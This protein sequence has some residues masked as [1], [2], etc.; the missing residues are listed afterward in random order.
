[1]ASVADC[2]KAHFIR[3]YDSVM[4]LL[5]QL[6][7][8]A[9][10]DSHKLLWAKSLECISLV[11]MAVGRDRFRTEAHNVMRCM[12]QLQVSR[13]PFCF[14]VARQFALAQRLGS[15]FHVQLLKLS[16][17]QCDANREAHYSGASWHGISWAI[18][19]IQQ[20]P[21]TGHVTMQRGCCIALVCKHHQVA[22]RVR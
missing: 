20:R 21:L 4:P 3:Y 2:A 7:T 19:S 14:H 1:M 11:G 12:Q 22:F 9:T 8:G 16:S 17:C 18:C 6:L 5:S 15:P 10:A 13:S